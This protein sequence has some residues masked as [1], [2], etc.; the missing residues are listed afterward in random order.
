MIKTAKALLSI[1]VALI[2]LSFTTSHKQDQQYRKDF[3]EFWTDVKENYA[4][5]DRKHTDWDKVKEVYLPLAE[6]AKTKSELIVV[7]EKAIEELY[8]NHFSLN[9][10][11]QSSTRLVPSG[12]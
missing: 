10:N 6:S 5:F 1:S 12:S 9:T 11:L 7:F 8:D 3:L 4:Y 2:L